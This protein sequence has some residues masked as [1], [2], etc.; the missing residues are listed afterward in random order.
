M[1]AYAVLDGGGVKGAALAGCLKGAQEF[2]I[3]FAGYGGT[4]AG[5]IV[6]LLSSIGYTADELRHVMCR[7]LNFSEFLDDG[8]SELTR[9]GATAKKLLEAQSLRGRIV[10]GGQVWYSHGK[11]LKARIE[12]LGIY[13]GANLETKLKALITRKLHGLE[14][15]AEITFAD[16]RREGGL[17]LKVVAA[18][19]RTREAVV[20]SEAAGSPT[21]N[22]ITAVRASCCYPVLFRPVMLGSSPF[23]DGGLASNLPVWLF[24][25]ERARTGLQVVA[26]DLTTKRDDTQVPGAY[27]PSDYLADM[28]ETALESGDALLRGTNERLIHVRVPLDPSFRTLDFAMPVPTREA[29]YDQGR[30]AA[31][32]EFVGRFVRQAVLA[33]RHAQIEAAYGSSQF[34]ETALAGLARELEAAFPASAP[35]RC[36]VFLPFSEG[37]LW[38]AYRHGMDGDPDGDLALPATAGPP[39][40][41]ISNFSPILSDWAAIRA[42]PAR[43]GLTT[44]H[45]NKVPTDRRAVASV[46]IFDGR[47][48]TQ[49][50]DNEELAGLRTRGALCVDCAAE[51]GAAGWSPGPGEYAP[52]LV[53][54]LKRWADV[55][56]RIMT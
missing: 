22:V 17:P 33:D 30:L 5:S 25:A 9:W 4:S 46:P 37:E 23:V 48:P 39:G 29:L 15:K 2:G 12:Q 18:H 16:L 50:V 13:V 27:G 41:A 38:S 36:S 26:F 52:E 10:K 47:Q 45:T 56:G 19:L 53:D 14:G 20:F 40:D 3:E 42:E 43:F 6:A 31:Q 51:A 35:V 11:D 44:W 21:N 28:I 55:I 24:D 1:K 7:D 34:F 54:I 32:S 49:V 8:G